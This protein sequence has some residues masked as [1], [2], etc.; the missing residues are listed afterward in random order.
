[1]ENSI[2]INKVFESSQRYVCYSDESMKSFL[3]VQKKKKNVLFGGDWG[4]CHIPEELLPQ[5]WFFV[6]AVNTEIMSQLKKQFRIKEDWPC[7]RL[8]APDGFGKGPWDELERLEQKD[9]PF[10]ARHWELQDE[11]VKYLRGRIKK[12]DSACV[13]VNGKPVAWGGLHFELEGVAE[14]GFAHTLKRYR[15]RGFGT[16]VTKAVVNRVA[17]HGNT[18]FCH[19]FKTNKESLGLC[20]KLGFTRAGEYTWAVVLRKKK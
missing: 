4:R 9:A 10:V 11:P 20:K 5:K 1:M 12:L 19:A 6:S 13:R 15:R 14:I 8:V 3:A 18:A 17:A 2:F 16:L 7:W